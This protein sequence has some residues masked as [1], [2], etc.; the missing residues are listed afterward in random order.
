MSWFWQINIQMTVNL[1]WIELLYGW[2]VFFPVNVNCCL[3]DTE[4]LQETNYS[5]GEKWWV[6]IRFKVS[7]IEEWQ[8]MRFG[9]PQ[10]VTWLTVC[11]KQ[12]YC[13]A[14]CSSRVPSLC[15]PVLLVSELATQLLLPEANLRPAGRCATF[16]MEL[17]RSQR[18]LKTEKEFSLRNPHRKLCVNL[19][20]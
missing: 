16:H 2:W 5:F 9:S 19:S 18:N 7:A 3:T 6:T 13:M 14:A 1:A 8:N 20:T 15:L 4:V 10:S 12:Y 11:T 17:F